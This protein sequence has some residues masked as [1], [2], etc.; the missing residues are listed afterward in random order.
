VSFQVKADDAL[1]D[2]AR[3]QAD[4]LASVRQV[5]GQLAALAVLHARGTT[6]FKD[7]TGNLRNS[8]KRGQKS[9]WALFVKAGGT[10]ARYALFIEA[11]SK[12][13]EI[14]A[15]RARF[16]KF[17]QNGQTV[18]RKRVFHPGTRPARFMQSARNASEA[19]ASQYIESGLNATI[20]R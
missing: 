14:K 16:L 2:L 17:E 4:M 15:R 20:N 3:V 5:L 8:I 12:P 19:F 11:G 7:R 9:P 10:G 18:F 6:T 13:H 1:R